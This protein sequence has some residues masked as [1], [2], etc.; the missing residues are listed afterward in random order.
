M[1]ARLHVILGDEEAVHWSLGCT[2]LWVMVRLCSGHRQVL[3]ATH[4]LPLKFK[5]FLLTLISLSLF[6]IR[7]FLFLFLA[8]SLWFS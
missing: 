5:S 8:S 2:L 4:L 1:V 3:Q 6:F 7:C